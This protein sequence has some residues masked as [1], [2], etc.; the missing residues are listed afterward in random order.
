M[1]RLKIAVFFIL[2][3]FCSITIQAQIGIKGI[4]LDQE[5]E[6]PLSNVRVILKKKG[7]KIAGEVLTNDKGEFDFNLQNLKKSDLRGL[8]FTYKGYEPE[9]LSLALLPNLKDIRIYMK[10]HTYQLDD[11]VVVTA[12]RTQRHL[13]QLPVPTHIIGRTQ[14]E[15]IAP[16]TMQELLLYTIPGIELSDHGGVTRIKI[17]GLD[18][19]Y[20][21]ILID[22]EEMAGMRSGSVDLSRISPD[23]I[24]RVEVVKGAGSALYGSNA[25]AGVINLITKENRKPFSFNASVG[26]STHK[27][28]NGDIGV[29]FR[30]KNF[31]NLTSLSTGIEGG[32]R[33]ST[34]KEDVYLDISKNTLYRAGNRLQWKPVENIALKWNLSGNTRKQ[35]L[36]EYQNDKYNY[37]NNMIS[38]NWG[39]SDKHSIQGSYNVDF[40]SRDRLFPKKETDNKVFLYKNIKHAAR[41]M[42]AFSDSKIGDLNIGAEGYK[43]LINSYQIEENKETKNLGY[44]VLFA[45]HLWNPSKHF[46]LL[47]GL[48]SD[49]HSAYGTHI[50]PKVSAS[51][52]YNNT[53]MRLGY[54]E[55]FKSPTAMELYFNWSH[56]GQF[57]ILGNPDLKPE[58]ARQMLLNLEWNHK[59][60]L[61]IN[62]GVTH[63][64][65]K[66][67][68]VLRVKSDNNRYFTN[69]EDTNFMT[70]ADAQVTWRPING[71][72]LSLSYLYTHD[73]QYVMVEGKKYRTS[74]SRPHNILGSIKWYKSWHHHSLS[75]NLIGQYYSGLDTNMERQDPATK[76]TIM[77]PVKYEGFPTTRLVVTETLFQRYSITVGV[78]NLIGYKPRSVSFQN[79]SFSPGRVFFGKLAYNF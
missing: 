33:L 23:M 61:N 75:V 77:L 79:A 13:E 32:Y 70:V 62:S 1:N 10:S 53:K 51:F 2:I 72:S 37:L 31:S 64:R 49:I 66:D 57:Y 74:L 15:K 46:Q 24:E 56:L 26:S 78:D 17:Q 34:Q 52:S 69:I 28:H 9:R 38:L 35:E 4:V 36:N 65:F 76:K 21:A 41:T 3:T 58:T 12:T 19:Q 63:T 29:G 25:I 14:I 67:R 44:F 8:I 73:P 5:I 18:S 22:G 27:Q 55:A 60:I 47:Y 48:R 7:G 68:I 16:T 71:L 59:N 54:Y 40:A 45:Q 42:Y 39:I 11:H 20:T 30:R 43:E 6:K 50:S